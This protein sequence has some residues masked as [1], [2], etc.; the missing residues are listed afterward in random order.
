MSTV[1]LPRY[2]DVIE[3][4][5]GLTWVPF[6]EE[7]ADKLLGFRDSRSELIG[8]IGRV[9]DSCGLTSPKLDSS[10]VPG[11]IDPFTV[12]GLFNKGISGA[13]RDRVVQGF[14]DALGIETPAPS[15]FDGVPVLNNLNATFYKF[16][17]DP[18]R[19]END[20]GYLWD[21]FLAALDHAN[22]P[23]LES[24]ARFVEAFD[25]VKDLKGNRWKTTMGLYWARPSSY[26]S[27]DSRNQWFLRGEAGLPPALL[28]LIGDL[29]EV[30]DGKQ[31]LRISA[32]IGQ[33]LGEGGY[34][35]ASIPELSYFAW[36]FS[37]AVNKQK[38]A[39]EQDAG[40]KDVEVASDVKT[41]TYWL[42]SPGKE[43]Y[44]WDELQERQEISVGWEEIGDLAAYE[45]K[46]EMKDAMKK[47]FDPTKTYKNWAHA[48]WQFAN[49]MKPGDIV[50]AK[51]GTHELVGRGIVK[52]GYRFEE[53]AGEDRANVRDVEWTHVGAW[54]HPGQAVMKTLTD[55]TPYTEYVEKLEALFINTEDGEDIFEKAV[56]YPTY[57]KSDYLEDVY[58]SEEEYE[59]LKYLVRT[60][61]NVILEGP[62]GV[63][64]TFLAKRLAF[65]LMGSE[66][67]SRLLTLQFHQS[68]A[69][70]DF[71]EG[72]RPQA[73][74]FELRKGPFYKFCKAAKI[75]S[76]NDYFVI[77]DEINRGN[78]SKIFGELF[79]L[80]EAD[81]R[82]T[83][84]NLLYS[85]ERFS[86]PSNVHLIGMMNTADR[87]LAIMDYALRRRFA[88]FA[89]H[90]AFDSEG[91][92]RYGKQLDSPQFDAVVSAVKGLNRAIEEDQ[93]LGGGFAVGHSYLSGLTARDVGPLRLR[94]IVDFEL[95]PLLREY[96]FDD[97]DKLA[98]WTK[99]LRAAT[100]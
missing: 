30:P 44:L 24:A 7:F 75:D 71:I 16:T 26:L 64:K 61:K 12:F 100:E 60:K 38:K 47:V 42:Y 93:T 51:K 90:P 1:D 17:G 39:T 23:S 95:V 56:A 99:R 83:E 81:K 91:F 85:E 27:L 43:A 15:D 5:P 13:N 41:P 45:S 76:D 21:V 8:L 78:L 11:D 77:I 88:F 20:I 79:T 52:S 54:P 36:A 58:M 48:T 37:E 14:R 94:R 92:T 34:P 18:E 65:S 6:Y 31:Y 25:R 4:S 82:E 49:E 66:D 68:Y 63:G 70:E 98:E 57:T 72:F 32:E 80:L 73:D 9:Y 69:Y 55:I 67:T 10:G 84:L 50:F 97:S 89:V 33:E 35:F 28:D 53:Q 40:L 46:E 86:I 29:T 59:T 62:P 22:Q 19:S 96:W 2:S 3:E 74:G 87:S